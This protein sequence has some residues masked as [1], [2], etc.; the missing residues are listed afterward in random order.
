MDLIDPDKASEDVEVNFCRGRL[1]EHTGDLEKAEIY[2]ERAARRNYPAAH[3]K[4]SEIF[5]KDGRI[6]DAYHSA[7]AA[8]RFG[9]HLGGKRVRELAPKFREVEAFLRYRSDLMRSQ[10]KE[11][12]VSASLSLSLGGLR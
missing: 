12:T 8:V 11:E 1:Y 3:R 5:E 10:P 2:Y 6:R 4:M 9:D 7:S